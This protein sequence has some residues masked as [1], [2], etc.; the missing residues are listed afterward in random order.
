MR[1]VNWTNKDKSK[2]VRQFLVEVF[3]RECLATSSLSGTVP[4]CHRESRVV[5]KTKLDPG[6]IADFAGD[7][8][9]A[10]EVYNIIFSG[11]LLSTAAKCI[12]TLVRWNTSFQTKLFSIKQKQQRRKFSILF[13]NLV[14]IHFLS[15]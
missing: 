12:I 10:A 4:N 5:A 15:F 3:G 13:R 6:K 1:A 2:R 14:D 11:V 8:L 9:Q 7:L